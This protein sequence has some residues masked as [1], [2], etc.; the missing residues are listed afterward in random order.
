METRERERGLVRR[1]TVLEV[2][3]YLDALLLHFIPD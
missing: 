1:G 3:D 2:E